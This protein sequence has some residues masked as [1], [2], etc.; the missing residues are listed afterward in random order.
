[1]YLYIIATYRYINKAI[2]L[3][4]IKMKIKTTIR[5]DQELHIKSK[6]YCELNGYN[7]SGLISVLLRKETE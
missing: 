7:L 2:R 6:E 5:M 1:M 3:R 4:R